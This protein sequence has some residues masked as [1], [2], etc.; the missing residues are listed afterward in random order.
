MAG[1]AGSWSDEEEQKL[2]EIVKSLTIDKGETANDTDT[3]LWS[4]VSQKMGYARTRNQC[5]DKWCVYELSFTR[6]SRSLYR[7][8]GP[9]T[10]VT[11]AGQRPRRGQRGREALDPARLLPHRQGVRTHRIRSSSVRP[12]KTTVWRRRVVAQD[13]SHD[14]E[15]D[16][17]KVQQNQ[18]VRSLSS[19][20]ASHIGGHVLIDACACSRPAIVDVVA[21]SAQE[22]LGRAADQGDGRTGPER[23]SLPVDRCGPI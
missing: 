14:T 4:V 9:L 21:S 7:L 16:W 15:I 12:L 6:L 22:A 13:V 2:I 23:T 19:S 20:R 17:A 11:Q 5:R 10:P 8:C 1:L 3:V 18:L